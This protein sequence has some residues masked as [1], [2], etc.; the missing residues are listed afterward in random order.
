LTRIVLIFCGYAS[1]SLGIIGIFLPI[2]PTTPFIL[3]ASA[4]F[5]R[6]SNKLHSWLTNHSVFGDY[7]FAYQRFKAVSGSAKVVSLVLLW[8]SILYSVLFVVSIL[9]VKALLL[10]IAVSV[11]IHLIRLKT[12]TSEMRENMKQE[13]VVSSALTQ[14][15]QGCKNENSLKAENAAA[16]R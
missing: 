15:K 6:S 3:L 12:L 1:L 4:C 8:A 2:L 14:K 16:E 10:L 13:R 5:L 7:I 9:W 11:S